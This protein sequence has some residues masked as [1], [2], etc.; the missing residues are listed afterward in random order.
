[1]WPHV[2]STLV[3]VWLMCAPAALDYRGVAAT[4]D[5]V[6]GPLVAAIAMIASAEVLR[7]LGRLNTVAGA[8]L[9][10]APWMFGYESLPAAN[11]ALAG[12][13]LVSL[14]LIRYPVRQRFGGGWGGVLT[15]R[16][17]QDDQPTERAEKASVPEGPSWP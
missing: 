14:S 8:W 11:S 2:L 13:M 15:G 6:T 5:H 4:V 17:A 1:M 3:G 7:P 9:V 10:I 16:L 12:L